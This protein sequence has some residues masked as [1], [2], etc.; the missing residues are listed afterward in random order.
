MIYIAL[1]IPH[2]PN[3]VEQFL[4][5]YATVYE[6]DVIQMYLRDTTTTKTCE[7]CGIERAYMTTA[8]KEAFKKHIK[9][10]EQEMFDCACN[11]EFPNLGNVFRDGISSFF[12]FHNYCSPQ[13]EA[14]YA[15]P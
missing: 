14:Q 13:K 4:D 8:N 9:N 10:H 7:Y 6:R 3:I 1:Q 5:T 11:I 15:L 12:Q 2:S